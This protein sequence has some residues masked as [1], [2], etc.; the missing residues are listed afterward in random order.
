ML[1]SQGDGTVSMLTE[2]SGDRPKLDELH[3]SSS[4]NDHHSLVFC[5]ATIRLSSSV[6]MCIPSDCAILVALPRATQ[7]VCR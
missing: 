4:Y 2:V 3:W 1:T 7:A 6:L 5:S